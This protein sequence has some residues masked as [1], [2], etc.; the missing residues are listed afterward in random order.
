MPDMRS[1]R[2]GNHLNQLSNELDT[3]DWD[4]DAV[5]WTADEACESHGEQLDGARTY[6]PTRLYK[7]QSAH[8]Y[9]KN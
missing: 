3:F 2:N 6:G 9:G 4:A 5:N 1:A 7:H 8:D